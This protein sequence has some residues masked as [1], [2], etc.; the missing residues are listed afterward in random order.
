MAITCDIC[1]CVCRGYNG[2]S[3]G[4]LAEFAHMVDAKRRKQCRALPDFGLERLKSN[5]IGAGSLSKKNDSFI[6]GQSFMF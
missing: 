6:E 1:F 4:N 5:L 2:C 3:L